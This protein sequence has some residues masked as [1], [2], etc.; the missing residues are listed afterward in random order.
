M[1][2]ASDAQRRWAHTD[3]AKKAGFPTAE[4]DAEERKKKKA[5]HMSD[6]LKKAHRDFRRMEEEEKNPH[7]SIRL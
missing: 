7:N 3:A 2:Y 6:A 5:K 1:P 4:F